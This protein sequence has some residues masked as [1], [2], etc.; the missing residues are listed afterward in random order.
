MCRLWPESKHKTEISREGT[1]HRA[2][3]QGERRGRRKGYW[4]EYEARIARGE[5]PIDRPRARELAVHKIRYESFMALK[6]RVDAGE[7]VPYHLRG[8]QTT[9]NS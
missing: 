9:T 5:A 2:E 7:D 4:V 1:T 3:M 8:R 6:T